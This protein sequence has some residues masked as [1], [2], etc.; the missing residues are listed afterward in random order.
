[1]KAVVVSR[2]GGPEVLEMRE[3][4]EPVPGP[5]DVLVRVRAAAMNRADLLQR[6][7]SYPA[8]A[9][10]PADIPGLEFAGEVEAFGRRASRFLPGARVMGLV[11]GGG[12]A[13]WVALHERLCLE[14]PPR[15]SFAEAA[16]IPEAF[17]TAYDALFTRGRLVAGD[18]LLVHAAASGVGIAIWQIAA[19]AGARAI[20]LSRSPEKRRR[21][22]NE[23]LE[24]V[25]DPASDDVASAIHAAA[26]ERGVDVVVDLLGASSWDLNLEVLAPRGRLVLVGTLGGS[27][28]SADL[29]TLMRKRITV[30]GTVLRARPIEEKIALVQE[31]GRR[32]LPLFASGRLRPIIDRTLPLSRSAEAHALME[33]NETFGKIV[34]DPDR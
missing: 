24:I 2:P 8:P 33:R 6:R 5:E 21:L 12:H 18:S 25:L 19:V 11:G 16:A 9:G 34:L 31:F 20:G 23:G 13:E 17:L 32:M 26:G 29:A 7:G 10:A 15:L 14:V 30:V 22:E 27:R 3:V 4:P 28:V 1:M